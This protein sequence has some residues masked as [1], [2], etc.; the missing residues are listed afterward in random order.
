MITQHAAKIDFDTIKNLI[1]EMAK[2]KPIETPEFKCGSIFKQALI[3][4]CKD[5]LVKG[6]PF[7]S[8]VVNPTL[9]GMKVVLDEMLPA[10]VARI[11]NTFIRLEN[12][13]SKL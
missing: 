11:G 1:D 3:D 7:A 6:V 5:V 8:E 4:N 2:N 10:N 12:S 13:Q 9:F